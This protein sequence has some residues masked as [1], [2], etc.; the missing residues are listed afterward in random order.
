MTWL[1]TLGLTNAVL[2]AL[3]AAAAYAI[4][5]WAKRPALT[6]VLW[7][8]VLIKLLTP[9]V[10]HV[11]IGL[12][13]DP[14]TWNEFLAAAE[15][16]SESLP[17]AKLTCPEPPSI[18]EK[19]SALDMAACEPP[20]ATPAANRVV[21]APPAAAPSW[22][23][24]AAW[25]AIAT[26]ANWLWA[27]AAVWLLGSVALALLY[28]SRARAFRRFLALA[29]RP[30][31]GLQSRLAELA[32]S[33]R[34]VSC[35]RVL[36]VE[37][38]ISPML[39]GLGRS[40]V[41]V[42]PAELNRELHP[43]ARDTLLLHELAHYARG[44][45]WVRLV[46]LAAQILFWWHPVVWWA[47]R[48]L[49]AAEEECCDAWVVER[50]AGVPRLYAEALLATI[51][52]LCGPPAALPPAACGLGDVPLL[53]LRLTQII[54]GRLAAQLC[55]AT[56]TAV[57][58]VA[59][60]ILPLGPALY[61]AAATAPASLDVSHA[62]VAPTPEATSVEPEPAPPPS[63]P[64]IA[65]PAVG[66]GTTLTM[67]FLAAQP[68]PPKVVPAYGTAVS[69]DGRFRLQVRRG[70]LV[71]LS[72]VAT[73]F[74]VEFPQPLMRCVAFSPDGQSFAAGF[75][76]SH[77]RI[78][79]SA[80]GAQESRLQGAAAP[81][82]SLAY[83]PDGR[84]LAAGAADGS[85][86]IWDLETGDSSTLLG[87][88]PAPVHCIRWSNDGERLAIS[89]GGDLGE[90]E[91]ASLVI[92]DAADGRIQSQF[93]LS[94]PAGAMAWLANDRALL[95]A[96]YN[97]GG[98]LWQLAGGLALSRVPLDKDRVSAAQW[99]PD[100]P[101]LPSGQIEQLVLRAMP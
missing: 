23:V 22:P 2:A 57:F 94:E 52:F 7:V 84:R 29:A 73:G 27:T 98:T 47:R 35:P 50:Q 76:D 28:A 97:G 33:A 72:D 16:A 8:L 51:D 25:R 89:L 13:V 24:A 77:V 38:V 85:A 90:P 93:A 4:G 40:V 58:L 56:K 75:A 30:D 96:D 21:T 11:P 49:E 65:S 55:P 31:A 67:A 62:A 42:F 87:A 79:D 81:I 12:S 78:Y 20:P 60:L 99:S 71:T 86:L 44:D 83:S 6:H 19:A 32:R 100:C 17:A 53:R 63:E 59:A 14:E 70:Y 54:R 3:L 82:R 46:E 68:K 101:L 10:F 95:L 15:P 43:A 92:Y 74:R 69:S 36:T 88:Q 80:R 9:P 64:T 61:G 45:H 37:S 48:E 26:P 18:S 41:L 1:V 91:S 39:F 34:L 5:R 66:D